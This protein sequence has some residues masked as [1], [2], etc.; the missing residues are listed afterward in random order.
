MKALLSLMIFLAGHSYAA[1]VD[2]TGLT[3]K[4]LNDWSVFGSPGATGYT[5]TP[6]TF[7]TGGT[8]LLSPLTFVDTV[9]DFVLNVQ[10]NQVQILVNGLGITYT[11]GPN[12]PN[13]VISFPQIP[14]PPVPVPA[15]AWLLGSGLAGLACIGRRARRGVRERIC[16]A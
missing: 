5:I 11:F 13:L 8:N 2:L 7:A 6:E 1:T 16:T 12:G 3:G 15:A 4:T 14:A 9:L 10:P